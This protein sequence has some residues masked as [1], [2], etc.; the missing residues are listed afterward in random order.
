MMS[1]GTLS[2]Y[3]V[4]ALCVLILRYRPNNNELKD[5]VQSEELIKKAALN[6][7]ND[8]KNSPP[9]KDLIHFAFM[10]TKT[11]NYVS[12]CVVNWLTGLAG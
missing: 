7:Q 1:I 4:V 11:C 9:F 6:A 8:T 2:A 12:S 5:L 3:S 10:P